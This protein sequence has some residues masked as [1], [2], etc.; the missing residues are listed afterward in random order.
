MVGTDINKDSI[1]NAKRNI[2][3]NNLQDLIHGK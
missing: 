3:K 2:E 1:E